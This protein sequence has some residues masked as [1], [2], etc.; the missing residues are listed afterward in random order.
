M[1]VQL[2]F[3][4]TANTSAVW[5]PDGR[6][7]LYV[8]DQDGARAIYRRAADGS[9]G[10]SRVLEGGADLMPTDVTA[11]NVLIYEDEGVAGSLDIF[12]FALDDNGPSM[13]YLATPQDER[14]ARISPDGHWLAY[15]S[16]NGPD[17]RIF[18]RT[19]PDAGGAQRAVPETGGVSPAWSPTGDEIY[20]L[21]ANGSSRS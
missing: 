19:Y 20:F 21:T 13:P 18:V 2:T 9:G 1:S 16:G 12:T 6:E 5:T 3:E 7:I 4:G 14:M 17:S 15:T 11:D 10:A 8:S